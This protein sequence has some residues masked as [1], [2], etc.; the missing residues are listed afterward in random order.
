MFSV[1]R[2][3]LWFGLNAENAWVSRIPASQCA[4]SA[5]RGKTELVNVYVCARCGKR[6]ATMN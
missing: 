6:N 1:E 3:W 5:A 4:E 2:V